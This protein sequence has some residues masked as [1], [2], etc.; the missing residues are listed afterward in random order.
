MRM[1]KHIALLPALL[2]MAFL[3]G[4]PY[5][6]PAAQIL[7]YQGPVNF[8]RVN[9]VGD[10][11]GEPSNELNAQVVF[12]VSTHTQRYFGFP[13]GNDANGPAHQAMFDLLREAY[14][15]RL[16]ITFDAQVEPQ[17]TNHRVI[18]IWVSR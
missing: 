11:F 8:L 6:G 12:S 2:T 5:A 7:N 9:E 13:L 14:I 17:K 16:P 10:V 1:I 3:P 15:R 18:R 4:E